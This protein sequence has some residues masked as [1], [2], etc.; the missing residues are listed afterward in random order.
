ML[1]VTTKNVPRGII[2]QAENHC[3]RSLTEVETSKMAPGN[4]KM[5]GVA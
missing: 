3:A 4:G 1:I 2:A 5:N